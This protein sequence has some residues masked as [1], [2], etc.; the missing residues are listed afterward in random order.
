VVR[1]PLRVPAR[2][3]EVRDG[4][5][6]RARRPALRPLHEAAQ[7]CDR[8]LGFI[9]C[10]GG[11]SHPLVLPVIERWK[12]ESALGDLELSQVSLVAPSL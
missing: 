8:H 2:S 6:A 1:I 9:E 11:Q 12:G 4:A 10:K 3:F 7:A 5:R